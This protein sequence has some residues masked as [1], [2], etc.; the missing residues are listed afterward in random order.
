MSKERERPEVDEFRHTLY[1][2]LG[3][4]RDD[5]EVR[6]FIHE[7]AHNLYNQAYMKGRN[8]MNNEQI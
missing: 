1:D 7:M 5:Y 4:E 6:D 3:I 2:H 8:K